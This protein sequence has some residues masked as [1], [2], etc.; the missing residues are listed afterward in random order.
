MIGSW[1]P[2]TEF[3]TNAPSFR[4][5]LLFQILQ[6]SEISRPT[7]RRLCAL[8]LSHFWMTSCGKVHTLI[9]V[10]SWLEDDTSIK[11]GSPS[12]HENIILLYASYLIVNHFDLRLLVSIESRPLRPLGFKFRRGFNTSAYRLFLKVCNTRSV[13]RLNVN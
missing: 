5:F 11:L 4:S 3:K 1:V 7:Y 10:S 9:G 2:K 8:L 12:S 13:K 6:C